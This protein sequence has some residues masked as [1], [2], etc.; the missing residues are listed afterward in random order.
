MLGIRSQSSE[1]GIKITY[2][3]CC[4]EKLHFQASNVD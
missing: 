3:E 4:A 2:G 1:I